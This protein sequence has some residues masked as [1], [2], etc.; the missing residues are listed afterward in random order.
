MELSVINLKTEY[1]TNPIGLVTAS[2][3]FSWE[4][5]DQKRNVSQTAWRIKCALSPDDLSV[6]ARLIWDSGKVASDQSVQLEYQGKK[7]TSGQ[8]VWWQVM[9]WT[10]KNEES[11]WSEPA[12]FE[13]GLLEKRDWRAVWIEPSADETAALPFLRKEFTVGKP[14]MKAI[15]Y[16]TCHGLYEISLNGGKVGDD[17][18][19]P[20]WT[21]YHKRLQYQIYDVTAMLQNGENAVGVILADGWYRGYLCW[22]GKRN[23]YGDRL[24]LLFQLKLVYA[25]GSE[26]MVISDESWKFSAGPLLKSDLYNGETYDARLEIPGWDRPGFDD[27]SWRAVHP[28]DYGYDELVASEGVPVCVTE[29]IRPV[30][31][32]RTPKGELVFDLGQNMVGRMRFR[33]KGKHGWKIT[34]SHAEVLDQ[35]GNFYTENLRSARAEDAYIF[36]GEG[37]ETWEPR[38]T[39]HGFRYV[40]ISDYPGEI[41]ADDLEGVVIHSH[42]PQTGWFECSDD[43]I[44]QLQKNIDWGLRGNFLDVPTDCPQRDERLG[45]TGDAQVFAPT[46]CFNRDVVS[47][48]GKWM[49]DFIPD[50][51]ADGSIPWVVPHV[52]ENG[53]DIG[54]SDGFGSAG[55]ADAAVIVPWTIYQLY[56]NKRILEEQYDSMKGWVEYMIREAGEEFVFSNGFHFGDWLSF[57]EYYSYKYKAPDYGYAG[58]TTDKELIATAYFYHSTGLMHQTAILLGRKDDAERYSDL[59]PKIK[60]AFQ[61][62]FMTPAGRLTSHTQTAYVLSLAFELLPDAVVPVAARRLAEDV[63]H[64]GHLTTGFLG[65]PLICQ[66]LTDQGYPELAFQLLFNKRYPSWLY[67]VTLGATTIWER[68][69][70]IKPD[71]SFQ[72]SG[73][74]SFNHYA[75]GAVG[76]WLY[77]RVAGLRAVRPGY[78]RILIK[79]F[80]T[81]ELAYA[82]AEHHSVYGKLSSCWK[83]QDEGLSLEVEI[84]VNTKALVSVPCQDLAAIKERN[85]AIGEDPDV[86]YLRTAEGRIELEVGSGQYLFQL[87]QTR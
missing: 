29:I 57:A 56:G 45:W 43:L 20:G 48:Y 16:V 59:L 72:T 71:G 24:G 27:S 5:Q 23:F 67:P 2:P 15:T 74:N 28:V 47:F 37:I 76:D 36:R 13:M 73:M 50:Q 70:G 34:L 25:D 12:F 87:R 33:L 81:D 66:A 17:L 4:I 69:D 35:D 86:R 18:F 41:G 51:R 60:S 49:K 53:A 78:K 26:E 79:P 77:S 39:F 75:Y 3:R 64:F 62:E 1:K 83:R 55:W 22:Q 58:A 31:K 46:A 80:L 6:A 11:G 52:L 14:I 7:L 44:N 38:F 63:S 40:R 54:W 65:T 82:K 8:R 30:E 21:S 61:K 10:S 84:P 19:T 32:L 9:V 68:W 42:M 85:R